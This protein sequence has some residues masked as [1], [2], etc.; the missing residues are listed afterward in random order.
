MPRQPQPLDNVEWVSRGELFS[1]NYNPNRVAPPE[2]KLLKISILE[3]GWTQPIVAAPNG[4]IIDGF[5]RWTV[6]GHKEIFELTGGLVPVV[7]VQAAEGKEMMATIRH[8]RARGTHDVR[9]M[10]NIVRSLKDDKNWTDEQI[11]DLLQMEPEEIDR[12]YDSSGSPK[13]GG[14]ED[15]GKGWVPT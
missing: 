7:R 4:Q 8:N 13:R 6:S 1:N 2:L 11:E 5:H 12:L 9:L 3:N 14:A 10:A 15:F